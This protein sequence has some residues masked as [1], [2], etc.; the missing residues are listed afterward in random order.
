MSRG[1]YKYIMLA[2]AL[3]G[4]FVGFSMGRSG[5]HAIR[6]MVQP[7]WISL[8]LYGAFGVYWSAAAKN[9]AP[10]ASAEPWISTA[11]HQ[12]LVNVSLLLMFLRL[13]GLSGRW[14]PDSI[15]FTALGVAVQAAGTALAF[16][17]R[18]HLG[19]NWSAEVSA[20][21][22][23]QLVQSGPYAM[24]RHPIYTG[25]FAIHSGMAIA[26][27]EYHALAGM[28]VLALAYSRKIRLEDETMGRLFGAEYT[29]YRA[30]SWA[31][32][33]WVL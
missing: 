30:H 27:G 14:L 6:S 9:S 8:A 20:K 21:V 5:L 12:L 29:A 4:A 23:H 17:A 11:T 18:K 32:I 2:G 16:W 13:P 7:M 31:L 19:S 22:G 24:L 15:T 10:T 25:V 28:A 1:R 26:S 3:V 33:P